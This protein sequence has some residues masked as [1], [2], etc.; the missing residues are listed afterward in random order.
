MNDEPPHSG[1]AVSVRRRF[2]PPL[3]L[4]VLQSPPHSAESPQ[5]LVD[6]FHFFVC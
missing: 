1:A 6:N 2:R 3:F 5:A 4:T